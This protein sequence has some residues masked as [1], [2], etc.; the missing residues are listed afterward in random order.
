MTW[1][2]PGV[3]WKSRK[4]LDVLLGSLPLLLLLLRPLG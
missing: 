1:T 3:F 4:K 2:A